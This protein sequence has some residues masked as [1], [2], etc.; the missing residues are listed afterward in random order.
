MKN[1]KQGIKIKTD[2]KTPTE[3]QGKREP[4][5]LRPLLLLVVSIVQKFTL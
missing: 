4:E 2:E 1:G 5:I 3:K